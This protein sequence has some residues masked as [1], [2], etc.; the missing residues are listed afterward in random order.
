M[1]LASLNDGSAN[2]AL[3]IVSRDL[4]F[5]TSAMDISSCLLNAV[6]RWQDVEPQLNARYNAL[7]RGEERGAFAFDATRCAAPLPRAPQWLDG[8]A[9][10]HH[11]NLLQQAFKNPPIADLESI[12]LMYQGASDDFLGPTDDVAFSSDGDGIDFEGEFGV[13]LDAVP[14][15]CTS[16]AAAAHIK[17]IVLI[18]DWSLRGLGAREIRTGFGFVQAKPSTSF[19]P[20]AVTPDELGEAWS[21]CRVK[22][23]LHVS[24]NDQWFGHPQ[25]QEMNF[26]FDQLIAHAA[27]TRRLRAGTII[28]SGTVSNVSRSSGSA[29][30]QERRVIEMIDH[31]AAATPFMHFGDRVRMQAHLADGSSVFGAI[32]QGVVAALA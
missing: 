31:G 18:N 20:V 24:L 19:A 21:D 17:L 29:C 32:A 13:V 5:A 2:G 16:H 11:G 22:L 10:L 23:P 30:I 14:M 27:A 8:S 15:A 1:K 28:G 25:G 3:I 9:F 4:R 26:G 12:P 6:D 7:N